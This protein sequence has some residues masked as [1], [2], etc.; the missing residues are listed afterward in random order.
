MIRGH[1]HHVG[2]SCGGKCGILVQVVEVGERVCLVVVAA[3]AAASNGTLVY[4]TDGSRGTFSDPRHLATGCSRKV[5][6]KAIRKESKKKKEG[7]RRGGRSVCLS[8]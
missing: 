5:S 6:K 4:C 1:R 2:V 3:G 7:G 8:L